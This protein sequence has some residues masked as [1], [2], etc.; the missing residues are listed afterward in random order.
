MKNKRSKFTLIILILLITISIGYAALTTVLKI[1]SN[2]ALGKAS[3]DIHFDNVIEKDTNSEVIETAHIT[4][5]EKTEISFNIS[6]PR[7][8]DYYRFTS[9][10]VNEG[11]IPAKIKSIEFNGL[12]ESQ[13]KILSYKV[14]YTISKKTVA[15]GDYLGPYTSKNITVEVVYELSDDVSNE[16]LP[17]DTLNLEC[18]FLIQFENGSVSE[19]RSRAAS[20]RL[21]QQT[22]YFPTS[23]VDFTRPTSSNEHEGIYRL[24]GTENDDFPIYFYRGGN[25]KVHN[26]VKLGGYCWRIIRTTKTGGIKIVYNGTPNENGGCT[27]SGTDMSLQ[28]QKFG[29]SNNY[30]TSTIKTWLATWYF[31]NLIQNQ[32]YLEDTEFCNDKSY[33]NGNISIDCDEDYIISMEKGNTYY[34]IGLISAQEANMTGLASGYSTDYAWLVAGDRGDSIWTISAHTENNKEWFYMYS[35]S[36]GTNGDGVNANCSVRPVVSLNSEVVFDTGDGTQDHP[37]TVSL[38]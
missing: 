20:N 25:A 29:S 26:H 12:T 16:D 34:P 30:A 14:F 17:T 37:Y 36:I 18:E 24:D 35:G 3:F 19:F 6:M 2:I 21:M 28:R 38:G 5:D 27:A 13:R 33:Y 22:D 31:E 11:S 8:G 9:D 4:N 10:I 1:N 23:Y 7:I 15:I 32:A